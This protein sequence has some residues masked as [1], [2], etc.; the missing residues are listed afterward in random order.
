MADDRCLDPCYEPGLTGPDSNDG[1]AIRCQSSLGHCSCNGARRCSG[2]GYCVGSSGSCGGSSGAGSQ[3]QI[4]GSASGSSGSPFLNQR[5][6]ATRTTT[7]R[8]AMTTTTPPDAASALASR[9]SEHELPLPSNRLSASVHVILA[10]SATT[11][12]AIPRAAMVTATPEADDALDFSVLKL[13]LL[14]VFIVAFAMILVCAGCAIQEYVS[15]YQK[16]EKTIIKRQ[17]AIAAD[18]RAASK[19]QERQLDAL[20]TVL[21]EQQHHREVKLQLQPV[22]RLVLPSKVMDGMSSNVV[23]QQQ[24]QKTVHLQGTMDLPGAM[25]KDK[26]IEPL[27]STA[28]DVNARV[29][30]LVLPRL[31][32]ADVRRIHVQPAPH[33]SPSQRALP[34]LPKLLIPDK[35]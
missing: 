6:A 25:G 1:E 11:T 22:E 35:R 27:R 10:T 33:F 28:C 26:E 2:S 20:P 3:G 31:R 7:R 16:E 19:V 12:M 23:H 29:A 4:S 21:S 5:A 18:Q 14:L 30:R 13:F 34:Q 8:T 32:E 9:G 17:K 24:P 15:R